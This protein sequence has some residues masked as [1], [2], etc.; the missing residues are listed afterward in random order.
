MDKKSFFKNPLI[1]LN[2]DYKYYKLNTLQNQ[3]RTSLCQN[4]YAQFI[5]N[6]STDNFLETKLDSLLF[7]SETPSFFN[8]FSDILNCRTTFGEIQSQI[9]KKPYLSNYLS[10]NLLTTDFLNTQ[11]LLTNALLYKYVF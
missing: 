11:F 2:L 4:P 5:N 7:A 8:T 10:L 3:K 1:I 6:I 9:V